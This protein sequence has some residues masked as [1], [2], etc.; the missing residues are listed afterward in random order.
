VQSIRSKIFIVDD[1][2]LVREWLTSLLREQP[3]FVV[4]GEAAE[5]RT[6]LVAME[7][8]PPDVAIV[9]LSL[10]GGSGL[11]LI[12]DLRDRMPKTAIVVLSMHEE[13]NYV[14]RAMRAG[15]L[16]YVMKRDSSRT[17]VEAI[18]QVLLGRIYA[19][20]EI[21]E[22]LATRLVRK[23][24]EKTAD[25]LEDLSDR[26]LEVFRRLGQGEGTRE[27]ANALSI[28]IKTVQ[29][30][31]LRIKEKLGMGSGTELVREAVRWNEKNGASGSGL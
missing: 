7:A 29:S 8:A 18:R 25:P 30:Y 17:I 10:K 15:A 5:A 2:S 27:I 1:H 16:G 20:Q 26:E 24:F 9:D 13:V 19:N 28:S 6:A 21:M 3:D 11:D 22:L 4:Q 12:K 23:P 31:C 14:E